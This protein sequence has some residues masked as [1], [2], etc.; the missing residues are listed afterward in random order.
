MLLKSKIKTLVES[1]PQ[2][3][4]VLDSYRLLRLYVSQLGRRP[5]AKYPFDIF[6]IELTNK[7][8]MKCIMCP[9]TLHM[10]RA[11]GFMSFDIFKK[12]ID[13][14]V[15]IHTNYAQEHAGYTQK[16]LLWLHHFGESLLHPEFDMFIDYASRDSI[17]A[18]L[19]VNPLMLNEET[20]LRLIR[21]KLHLVL[22][23]LDGHD[24]ASF[25][26]IR[27]AKNAYDTSKQNVL[28]F[29]ELK[30]SHHSEIKTVLSMVD[31]SEN[32]ESIESAR[33][34]WE[35]QN[36]IDDF[37]K[38]DFVK[39]TGDIKDINA[40]DIGDKSQDMISK[41]SKKIAICSFPFT[42]MTITWDGDVVPCCYDYDKKYV[43]GSVANSTLLEIW[44]GERMKELRE[45][46]VNNKV[47][48]PLCKNCKD[49]PFL[50]NMP[51]HPY[52]KSLLNI[53]KLANSESNS[54]DCVNQT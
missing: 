32:D 54:K 33:I 41:L 26:K 17:D 31:F 19:S 7:C 14:L 1:I 47:R 15:E 2:G 49:F 42:A 9:R 13:E 38:K 29:L 24:N 5:V 3:D 4:V 34:F 52:V 10:T 16:R 43:L 46:F 12:A 23:S 30:K 20:A 44:N 37:V 48:N 8:P 11:Q 35:C 6:N 27:G 25:Y 21:S 40:L 51:L 36:G 53:T 18:A 45:E 39:W 22:L 28:N 50:S